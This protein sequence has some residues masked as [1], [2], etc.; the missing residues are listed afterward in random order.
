M[1]ARKKSSAP[2]RTNLPVSSLAGLQPD[3]QK[4][5][6]LQG[7]QA[8]PFVLHMLRQAGQKPALRVSG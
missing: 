4:H 8:A 6:D 1:C 2:R 7:F 5:R 3:I